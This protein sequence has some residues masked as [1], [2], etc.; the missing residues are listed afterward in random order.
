MTDTTGGASLQEQIDAARAD[1]AF[2][3]RLRTRAREDRAILDRL[4]GRD[5]PFRALGAILT[6]AMSRCGSDGERAGAVI[7]ALDDNP[8]AALAAVPSLQRAAHADDPKP[9]G[10]VLVDPNTH[11]IDWDGTVHGTLESAKREVVDGVH[12]GMRDLDLLRPDC[13]SCVAYQVMAVVPV[14]AAD[15]DV[16]ERLQRAWDEHRERLAQC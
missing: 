4:A 7:A 3:G 13:P 12:D 15:A 6:A 1:G 5:D 8:A 14:P 9:I 10:Y 16:L 2:T 11:A